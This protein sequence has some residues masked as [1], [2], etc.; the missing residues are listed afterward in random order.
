MHRL[1]ANVGP[2]DGR[3]YRISIPVDEG[4]LADAVESVLVEPN[5]RWLAAHPYAPRFVDLARSGAI[6]YGGDPDEW[7]LSIPYSLGVGI[8]DC[9]DAAGWLAAEDR[10]YG[11]DSRPAVYRSHGGTYHVIVARRGP[12]RRGE[13]SIGSVDGY[14]LIDPAR[15]IGMGK[16]HRR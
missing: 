9:E 13:I 11:I 16:Y 1:V 8:I 14:T 4:A 2:P 7:W 3:R 6:R 12:K 15:M 5:L 10:Y